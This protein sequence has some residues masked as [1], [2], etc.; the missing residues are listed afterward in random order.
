MVGVPALNPNSINK[1]PE[2]IKKR[3]T[4]RFF[5]MLI[6]FFHINAYSPCKSKVIVNESLSSNLESPK[7]GGPK[8]PVA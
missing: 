4:N 1:K 8:L 3:I 5:Q 2:F 6:M 7:L